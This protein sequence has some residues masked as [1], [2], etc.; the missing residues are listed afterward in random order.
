[1]PSEPMERFTNETKPVARSTLDHEP[2]QNVSLFR[3]VSSSYSKVPKMSRFMRNKSSRE[4]F[5]HMRTG[6]PEYFLHKVMG[7]MKHE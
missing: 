4:S 2:G 7:I 3:N 5:T 1:M 6:L